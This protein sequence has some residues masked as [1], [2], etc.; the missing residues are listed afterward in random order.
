LKSDGARYK[1]GV[2]H[3]SVGKKIGAVGT[4]RVIKKED[5]A[6]NRRHKQT[7]PLDLSAAL[8][9]INTK[10]SEWKSLTRRR[11]EAGGVNN[12]EAFEALWP[13]I[14]TNFFYAETERV[15]LAL[16][17]LSEDRNN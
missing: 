10:V 17:F 16:G 7:P 4:S 8:T 9:F 11:F 14:L 6:M 5:T 3:H 1:P 2:A 15:S 13:P 12:P